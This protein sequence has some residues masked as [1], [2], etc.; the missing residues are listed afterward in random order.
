ME[1]YSWGNVALAERCLRAS[2]GLVAIFYF[3]VTP[4]YPPILAFSYFISLYLL[5]T[6]LVAWDPFYA[7]FYKI[8]QAFDF[9]FE[10]N[11]HVKETEHHFAM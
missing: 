6:A 10:N 2:S 1:N 9:R 4:V 11:N 7:L 8:T 3:L 5:L